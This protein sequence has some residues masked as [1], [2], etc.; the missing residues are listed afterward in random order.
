MKRDWRPLL[1]DGRLDC[2]R[3]GAEVELTRCLA[4]NWLLDLDRAGSTPALRCAAFRPIPTGA[5]RGYDAEHV[6]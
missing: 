4:C 6:D 2:E 5:A 1:A 3:L